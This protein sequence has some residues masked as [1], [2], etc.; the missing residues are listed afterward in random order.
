MSRE[1]RR[2]HTRGEQK[3]RDGSGRERKE[4]ISWRPLQRALSLEP[5]IGEDKGIVTAMEILKGL[6]IGTFPLPG[7]DIHT[8]SFIHFPRKWAV[9]SITTIH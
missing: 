6:E 9:G 1:G 2:Q 3:A 7:Q 8:S 4:D 5:R